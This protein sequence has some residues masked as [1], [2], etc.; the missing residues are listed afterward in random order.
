MATGHGGRIADVMGGRSWSFR[1]PPAY[2]SVLAL[3]QRLLFWLH[4]IDA[5][6]WASAA[7]GAVAA[8]VVAA[9]AWRICAGAST[10]RRAAVAMIAGMLFA[11]NPLLIG[12]SVSLMSEGL[13]LLAIASALLLADRLL[14]RGRYGDA[15]ALGFV[16]GV[17]A[18][19]RSEGIVLVAA[20]T[21][22][23]LIVARRHGS[24]VRPV[25]AALGIGL[26]FPVGW[27]V[28]AST[29]AGRPVVV[30]TNGGSLL[31][32]ATCP[33]INHDDALGYWHP[34][35]HVNLSFSSTTAARLG[36]SASAALTNPWVVGPVPGPT[37]DA[38][39]SSAMT[40]AAFRLMSRHPLALAAAIP[41]RVARGLGLYWTHLQ[42]VHETFEGR[43]HPWEIAG[44]WF[45]LLLVLPLTIVAVVAFFKRTG[46]GRRLR[47]LTDVERLIPMLALLIGW[48]A[49][50]AMTYGSTR[51]RAGVEPAL[52]VLAGLGAAVLVGHHDRALSEQPMAHVGRPE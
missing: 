50:V 18:L 3:G 45:H 33:L 32:G 49:L 29:T 30:G 24:R 19:T 2:P 5:D 48:L 27:S 4:P 40:R 17:A 9:L 7:L 15:V 46:I 47:A 26:L 11:A 28:F 14:V 44:R 42:D 34:D 6:L 41:F 23:M 43:S 21:L 37:A 38:E 52:A 1:Y 36:A 25:L 16:F 8:G 51:L 35:C 20:I 31:L 12:A 22:G 13:Y 10:G 39:G